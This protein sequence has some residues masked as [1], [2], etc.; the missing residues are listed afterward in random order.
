MKHLIFTLL[1]SFTLFVQ[2]QITLEPLVTGLERIVY[3]THAQDTRL[4]I[5]EQAG[6]IRIFENNLLQP[7]VFLDISHLTKAGGERGLL[8]LAFHPNYQDNGFFF[9]NYTDTNGDTQIARYQVSDIPNQA[10]PD[11]GKIILSI[12][13]PYGNHNGGMIAFGKDG[14]LYIGMGDG[15]SGGDPQNH[16]QNLD[17]L[18]GKILRIDVDN[19]D[20]YTVPSDNP[21]VNQENAQPEIWSYGWR[22]PWRFSFDRQ[23]GDLWVG[24]VGQGSYEEISFQ[25]SGQSGDNYGWRIMEGTYCYKPKDCTKDNLIQPIFEYGHS[26]GSSITGGYRYRGE[27]IPN[28]QGAYV[29]GDFA[30]GRLWIGQENNGSWQSTEVLDTDYNISSFGEDASGELYLLDYKGVVYQIRE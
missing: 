13:Q 8:G 14:Y 10:N 16:A 12:D 3:L 25:A 22:N 20:P 24:D 29:F 1:F 5:V 23:T 15:G 21:F 26:E 2:A 18:L 6:R 9:V 7:Q 4:F 30:S 11:S 17:S 19:G 28:L 27:S